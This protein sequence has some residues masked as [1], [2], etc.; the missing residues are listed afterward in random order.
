MTEDINSMLNSSRSL[1]ASVLQVSN[2]APIGKWHQDS[3]NEKGFYSIIQ[4]V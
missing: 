3:K 4:F 2:E 1:G